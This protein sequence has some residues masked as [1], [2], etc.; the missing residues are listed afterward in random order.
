MAS[1]PKK[2]WA[3]AV[4]LMIAFALIGLAFITFIRG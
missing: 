4:A 3:A 1:A 2:E